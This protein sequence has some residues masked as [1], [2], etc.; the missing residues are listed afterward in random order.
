MTRESDVANAVRL[1][2]A[3]RGWR[4]W[5]NNSGVLV[6]KRGVPIRY[7]LA[8]ESKAMNGVFK[9]GDFIGWTP[10]GRFVSIEV[11]KDMRSAI[12]PAQQNWRDLVVQSGGI[13]LI[14]YGP[15]DLP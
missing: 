3:S 10:D 12:D 6:D 7:G 8:N 4:L 15:E 13:G 5:R 11:K 1:A 14:V 9:S 2:A